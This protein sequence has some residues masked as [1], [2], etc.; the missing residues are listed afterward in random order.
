VDREH[1]A[2]APSLVLLTLDTTR[3]DRLGAYGDPAAR[4]PTLDRLARTGVLFEDA[5]T[6]VP[7]TLP[8]HAT[9]LTGR[10]PTEHGVR[11]NALDSLATDEVTL[12]EVLGSEGY[13]AAG[14][15]ASYVLHHRFGLDQG[16]ALFDDL[17]ETPLEA[18]AGDPP[19]RRAAEVTDAALQALEDMETTSPFFLWVHYYDPHAPLDPP[20]PFRSLQS[21]SLYDG[22]VAAMD[23]EIGRLLSAMD[24]RGLLERCWIVAV[25]DHGEGL[26]TP[27]PEELHGIFLYDETIRVP[28]LVRGPGALRGSIPAGL[29]RTVD[30]FATILDLLALAPPQRGSGTTLA[31][32]IL[33]G[34]PLPATIAYAET[35]DPWDEF[36]WSPLHSV[37]DTRWKWIDAPTPELYDLARD[38]SES[39]NVAP[40]EPSVASRLA[41]ALEAARAGDRG[42]EAGRG[43]GSSLTP[44]ERER[45]RRLGYVA[46]DRPPLPDRPLRDP[47]ETIRLRPTL[48]RAYALLRENAASE[49]GAEL[50]EAALRDDPENHLALRELGRAYLATGRPERAEPHLAR[51]AELDGASVDTLA[52]LARARLERAVVCVDEGRAD[53]AEALL[54]HADREAASACERA[55]ELP[56]LFLLLAEILEARG[57]HAAATRRLEEGIRLHPSAA[58]L[59]GA[60]GRARIAAGRTEDGIAFFERAIEARPTDRA[61]LELAR[62]LA[63]AG[64]PAEARERLESLLAHDPD[65]AEARRL[66]ALLPPR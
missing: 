3:H 65:H 53:E 1:R 48:Y 56:E 63:E 16:F 13:S 51:L 8:A 11:N 17:F 50:L 42:L 54:A 19:S 9:M 66:L 46:D 29:A 36:G 21:S 14:I 24:R 22:E 38:P 7:L 25:G 18:V 39:R 12:A 35:L 60:L 32:A 62:A 23:H 47:K 55:P 64:R 28:L 52:L 15:V 34:A 43:P 20:E 10:Y 44:E 61:R 45:L 30:L 37:R 59:L 6:A 4:T 58:P 27:H 26:G 31:P 33:E 40:G 5:A 57:D 2:T 49:E 41:A